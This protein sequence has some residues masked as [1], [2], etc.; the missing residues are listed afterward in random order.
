MTVSVRGCSLSYIS[1]PYI[2][3]IHVSCLLGI[4]L[5]YVVEDCTLQTYYQGRKM[6]SSLGK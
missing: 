1:P 3:N 2:S 5:G 6:E 4:C